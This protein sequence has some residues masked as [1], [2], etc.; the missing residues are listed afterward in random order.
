MRFIKKPIQ[1][2]AYQI[3]EIMVQEII[4]KKSKLPRGLSFLRSQCYQDKVVNWFGSVTTIHGQETEV[5]IGDWIIT[6][7]DGRHF[8]PCKPDIF[9]MTYDKITD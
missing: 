4:D 8:Y 3:T 7:P 2:D 9:E 1:I 5:T 6:E